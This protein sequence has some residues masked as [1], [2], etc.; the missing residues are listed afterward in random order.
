MANRFIIFS[1]LFIL[2]FLKISHR[3]AY[4]SRLLLGISREGFDGIQK[5]RAY[6][7][8]FIR[9]ERGKGFLYTTRSG[10]FCMYDSMN[11]HTKGIGGLLKT[12][13]LLA[14]GGLTYRKGKEGVKGYRTE[15]LRPLDS[16]H[17][18]VNAACCIYSSL[19]L[20]HVPSSARKPSM[21]FIRSRKHS[22]L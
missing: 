17:I 21:N 15:Y 13:L 16:L 3:R 9:H 11:G 12:T 7:V 5:L 18:R 8:G 4:P 22:V 1:L 2:L 10:L 19:L 6:H 20:G 14:V